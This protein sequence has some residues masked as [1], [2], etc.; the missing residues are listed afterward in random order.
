M[1]KVLKTLHF[2]MREADNP[3]REEQRNSGGWGNYQTGTG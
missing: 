3:S 2:K 1:P